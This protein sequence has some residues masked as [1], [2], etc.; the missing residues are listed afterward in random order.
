MTDDEKIDI[1]AAQILINSSLLLRNWLNDKV[2]THD[3]HSAWGI[4]FP[5]SIPSTIKVAS[6]ET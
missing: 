6:P 3:D 4:Q 1:V 5:T 2:K